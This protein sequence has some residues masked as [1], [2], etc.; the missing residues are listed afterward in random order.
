LKLLLDEM[1]PP[2]LAEALRADGIEAFTV[3]ERGLGGRSDSDVLV[4]AAEAGYA[5]LT[6]NVADFVRLAAER[7]S[8]GEH[9]AGALIA[10]SPRF[11]R[12]PTGVPN[13]AAVIRSLVKE[14]LRDRLLYLPRPSQ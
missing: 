3:V 12:R 5:L 4:S 8:A 14:D 1:Y 7:L 9:H 11:S 6:E 10:L 2:T 13:I